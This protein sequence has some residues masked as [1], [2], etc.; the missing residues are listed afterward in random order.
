MQVGLANILDI[1]YED[2]YS[3]PEKQLQCG[4]ILHS[5]NLLS[6]KVY[7]YEYN[8]KCMFMCIKLTCMCAFDYTLVS[9]Q[10]LIKVVCVFLG[11]K[12]FLLLKYMLVMFQRN[13][14]SWGLL[15]KTLVGGV[16]LV[17]IGAVGQRFLPRVHMP[18][19]YSVEQPITSLYG[20]SSVKDQVIEVAKVTNFPFSFYF[21]T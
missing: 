1:F 13:Y 12:S 10:T 11:T 3:L 9:L 20:V 16:F 15:S 5:A 19:Q 6:K 17:V 4:A 14:S 8:Y 18:G 2:V 21:L 7:I